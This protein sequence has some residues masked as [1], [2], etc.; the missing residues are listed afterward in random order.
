MLT[1]EPLERAAADEQDVRRVDLDRLAAHAVLVGAHAHDDLL[2]LE[3]LQEA[4]LHA[5]A[6]DVAIVPRALGELVDLVEIDDALLRALD[7]VAGGAEQLGDHRLDVFADVARLGERR[8]VG[9]RERN[10]EQTRQ[11]PR[12]VRLAGAGRAD[13]DDIRLGQLDIASSR[14]ASWVRLRWL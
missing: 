3:D 9:H 2:A 1:A 4:L 8:R 7:V 13:E 12:E 11:R 6:R 5:F 14:S 10:I